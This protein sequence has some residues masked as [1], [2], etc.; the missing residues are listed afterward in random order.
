MEVT[1]YGVENVEIKK[2]ERKGVLWY[3]ITFLKK[4]GKEK[5]IVFA[6]HSLKILEGGK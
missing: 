6:D 2:V 5:V 3:E 4:E 1:I